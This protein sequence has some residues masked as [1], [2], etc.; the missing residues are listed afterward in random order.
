MANQ[1]KTLPQITVGTTAVAIITTADGNE[2]NYAPHASVSVQADPANSGTLYVGDKF[3]STT[4]YAA[5]LSPGQMY[6][7]AGSA[8]NPNKIY[9][10]GSAAG[11]NAHVSLT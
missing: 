3:L 1:L 4:Q 6:T 11:Q 9:V 5:A 8:I 10:L 7:V 2:G